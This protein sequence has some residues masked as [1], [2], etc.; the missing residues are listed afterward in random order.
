[1]VLQQ[2]MGSGVRTAC[3]LAWLSLSC[4]SLPGCLHKQRSSMAY[5]T[6]QVS[7]G[8][9]TEKQFSLGK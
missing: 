2:G 9:Q 7:P 3:S 8:R 6:S 5:V 1:M 4:L